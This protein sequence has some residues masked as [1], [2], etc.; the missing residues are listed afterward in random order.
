MRTLILTAVVLT[1]CG[2]GAQEQ[3]N[4]AASTESRELSKKASVTLF[5]AQGICAELA[6]AVGSENA[7]ANVKGAI[8]C[9][10]SY[11]VDWFDLWGPASAGTL[12]GDGAPT[13]VIVNGRDV[14]AMNVG[15]SQNSAQL[16]FNRLTTK[17]ST[18]KNVRRSSNGNIE[19][20]HQP[21]GAEGVTCV[22]KA[23]V[24]FQLGN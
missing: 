8:S 7:S 11:G 10:P 16:L 20:T 14:A 22:L 5:T 13:T 23:A 19:C 2:H 9:S 18:D 15:F 4:L 21:N 12:V 3:E 6:D 24:H 17:Y 1:S